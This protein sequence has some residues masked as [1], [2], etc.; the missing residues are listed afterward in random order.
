[1][2]AGIICRYHSTTQERV[3]HQQLRNLIRLL[4]ES[5][6]RKDGALYFNGKWLESTGK[7]DGNGTGYNSRKGTVKE[8]VDHKK[9]PAGKVE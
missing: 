4:N 6:T 3:I 9:T 2:R 8:L 1:M 7:K 5:A